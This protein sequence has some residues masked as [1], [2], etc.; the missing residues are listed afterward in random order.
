MPDIA[1]WRLA[2]DWFDVCTCAIFVVTFS[3][4]FLK[5]SNLIVQIRS[6]REDEIQGLDIPEMGAEAYPDFQLTD[7]TSPKVD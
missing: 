3:F 1:P 7:R 4:I 5:I 6:K 2:G